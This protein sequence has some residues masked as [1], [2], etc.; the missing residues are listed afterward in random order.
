M[1]IIPLDRQL[2]TGSSDQPA[3]YAGS[4]NEAY[5]VLLRVEFTLPCTVTSH[6]VR[7]YRTISPLPLDGGLLSVALVV[8]FHP[9]DVI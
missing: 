6:A 8:D 9:L 5:L 7:S 4:V 1:V 3:P 2:L